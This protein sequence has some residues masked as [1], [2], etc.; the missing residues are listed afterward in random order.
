MP[1]IVICGSGLVWKFDKVVWVEMFVVDV[2]SWLRRLN[3]A[4]GVEVFIP[5]ELSATRISCPIL[6]TPP[7]LVLC[8]TSPTTTSS[9]LCTPINCI[10]SCSVDHKAT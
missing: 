4:V 9:A 7:T 1:D 10:I 5:D 8:T 3:S 2:R 6:A